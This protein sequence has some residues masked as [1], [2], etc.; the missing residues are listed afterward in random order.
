[1]NLPIC[2][3][4]LAAAV[5]AN[6]ATS[7]A[8][9]A[10]VVVDAE[11]DGQSSAKLRAAWMR[12]R[13]GIMVHWLYPSYRDVDRW[14]D[15]FDVQSFLADFKATG[16]D[17]LV[18]TAGQCRGAYA[19][20]NATFERFCGPGHTPRR[21]L[22]LE[23]ARG[24]KKLGRR[25]VIYSAAEF[26]KDGCDDHSMQR[27][28]CWDDTQLDRREFERRWSSV[29][30]EWSLRLGELC[31]GWWLDGCYCRNYRAG[32]DWRLWLTACRAGNPQAAV[33]FNGGAN[34]PQEPWGPSDYFA[35]EI[36]TL[37]VIE[38]IVGHMLPRKDAV[39]HYLFPIDG[40]WGAYWPWPK[41]GWAKTENLQ[42]ERPE[43]FDKATMDALMAASRFPDPIYDADRLCRFAK[44]AAATGAGIT[45][46]VGISPEG[47][48]NPK[49]M[50]IVS[51]VA[52]C[53]RR[54]EIAAN[55]VTLTPDDAEVVI[56]AKAPKAVQFAAHE[57]TNF[58]SRV[59]GVS[60]P[61]VN[62]P[63]D[64]KA[65][66]IL[67][68]NDWSVAAGIDTVSL[69]RDAFV[70][71]TSGRRIFIAGRDDPRADIARAMSV[72]AA[73]SNAERA[74][75]FGVY[76]FLE[77]VAG[78]R[79]FF[80]GEFG[81]I[82]PKVKSLSVPEGEKTVAPAFLVRDPYL[83]YAK[84]ARPGETE[85]MSD[86]ERYV[87][88]TKQGNID[89]LR[90]RLQTERIPCNH[91]QNG[92]FYVE[93]FR[94]T[95]PEYMRL[96][97]DGTRQTELVHD[98]RGEWTIR[99]LCHTSKVWDEIYEDVK[100]YLT[101]K[102]AESRGIPSKWQKGEFCW[103]TN[104]EGRKYVD[105][106]PQDGFQRC[107]CENCK[108]AYTDELHYATDL[109][110]G[111]TVK[112]AKRLKAEGVNGFVTQ[113][114]YLP[115]GRVPDVEIPDNVLVMVAHTGP[116][117][118]TSPAELEKEMADYRAWGEKT[119]GKVWCWTYPQKYGRSALPDVPCVAPK[120]WG[121]YYQMASPWIFGS[122]A[123]CET[124]RAIF[125]YLNYYVFSKVAWNP[126]LD[127]DALLDD[128]YAKM[129]G[130][131]AAKMKKLYEELEA[132]WL[133]AVG[134][135]H[136]DD[137]GP[138]TIAPSEYAL[139]TEVYSPTKLTRWREL[140]KTAYAKCAD[141]PD[142][143]KR[144][145]FICEQFLVGMTARFRDY[146]DTI[147]VDK[148]LARRAAEPERPNLAEPSEKW[149]L[150]PKEDA[151]PMFDETVKGPT[152]GKVIHLRASD[153]NRKMYLVGSLYREPYIL[154]PNAR[155]RLSCFIKTKDVTGSGGVYMELNNGKKNWKES[156]GD[157]RISGTTDWIYH[158]MEF[159][160]A[161][162]I[163]PKPHFCLRILNATG[164]AGFDGL[165]LEFLGQL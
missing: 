80:P 30:K 107:C 13:C 151:V 4:A 139:A 92:F 119:G 63:S 106:M 138:H 158:E 84:A 143:R 74:T 53:L 91:G 156:T 1:M 163:C 85:E 37:D 101:G 130:A 134:V 62:A 96:K 78:C 111:Q 35:G 97:P 115:Y 131:G 42:K 136:W 152:G 102:S 40:Y 82:V 71:K 49:S 129:F 160:T 162:E 161:E 67:G 148:A 64:G 23:I 133:A 43:L 117:N 27:G 26:A 132:A 81:T 5:A 141:D 36:S 52:D 108:R 22:V 28:L 125:N 60:V 103:N 142:A 154:K 57:A 11:A 31:D 100:A 46:N 19:S 95:H 9:G 164:D 146:L 121:R 105:I 17:W 20:P 87:F 147:S 128:H 7:A 32:L 68:S 70:M 135:V 6:V 2:L 79:F 73:V 58:L 123:E 34:T 126:G 89:W 38:P 90:L 29:L 8:A 93:R 41:A 149:S 55:A 75:L 118:T 48:L 12:K 94:E 112:L 18:F 150:Y 116:W 122:F 145:R 16:A 47:R 83:R 99:H 51:K 24:V 113:M 98:G 165:R 144:I 65:S 10:E 72:G 66:I 140:C 127:L 88:R 69:K 124:D 153:K 157:R 50:T 76:Q 45:L 155:Y 3:C 39:R 44:V 120:A 110:W 33:T 15:A 137:K 61:V 77:D 59:L 159:E 14:V 109:I 104:C 21:D 86:K 25:F 114:S 56:D 54:E